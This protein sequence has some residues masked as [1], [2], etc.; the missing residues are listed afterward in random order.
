MHMS[1]SCMST[2][3]LKHVVRKIGCMDMVSGIINL[4]PWARDCREVLTVGRF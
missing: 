4:S 1:P 2:G 3:R